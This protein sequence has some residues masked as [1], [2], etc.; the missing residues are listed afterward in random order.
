MSRRKFSRRR[1]LKDL[2]SVSVCLP[3][4]SSA[5][6]P[7]VPALHAATDSPVAPRTRT[8][9]SESED[10]FLEDL[11]RANFLYFWEQT[12]PQTGLVKDRCNVRALD[13]RVLGS[14]A[15]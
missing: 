1:L 6:F 12:N 13:T 8:D 14:I 3:L 9:L 4:A 11:E 10:A 2:A 15:A 5:S 7:L